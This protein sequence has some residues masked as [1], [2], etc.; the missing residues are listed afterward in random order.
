MAR[1]RPRAAPVTMATRAAKSMGRV[2]AFWELSVR[3]AC[4]LMVA[5]RLRARE[6]GRS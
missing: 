1:P 6:Y 5:V 4:E 2:L 3:A